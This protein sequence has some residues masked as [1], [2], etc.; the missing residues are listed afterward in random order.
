MCSV[1]STGD[2]EKSRAD[3]MER[4]MVMGKN[5]HR[6]STMDVPQNVDTK[7]LRQYVGKLVTNPLGLANGRPVIVPYTSNPD[8]IGRSGILEQL[9]SQLRHGSHLT[10]NTSQPR[11]SIHGL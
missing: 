4:P 1:R 10:D 11:V 7:G 5:H 9:R 6:M 2:V 8:F 3:S